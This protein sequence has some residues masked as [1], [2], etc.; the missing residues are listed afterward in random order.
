MI[1]VTDPDPEFRSWAVEVLDRPQ[2]TILTEDLADA[3]A[4]VTEPVNDVSVVLVGPNFDPDEGLRALERMH[5][6]V[7]DL[8]SILVSH[9]GESR[10]MQAAMR[11]GVRDVL[12]VPVSN[13]D[14]LEAVKRAQDLVTTLRRRS[15]ERDVPERHQGKVIT[16]FSSKGGCGKSLVSSNLAILLAQET[17]K[18]VALVDLD[19]QSGDQ[20][21]ML[22]LLPAL[23]I[24]DVSM[25]VDRID[26]EALQGYM[27]PH[28]AGIHVLAAPLEPSVAEAVTP[29]AV[30]RVLELLKETY[31]YIVVDGPAHFTD[32]ILAAFDLTD[33]LLMVTSMDV[34]SIKNLK[35]ALNTVQ[36]LGLSRDR[37]KVVLNR[38]DSKVGL[39]VS[40]V[41][42]TLGTEIDAAL[43]SSR[44]VPL[45][46]NQGVP[47]ALQRRKSP[48]V[49]AIAGLLDELAPARANDS[50]DES[51]VLGLFRRDKG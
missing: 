16:V 34:P 24:Y 28:R 48:V 23:S 12:T 39:R 4:A 1:V 3:E 27:T 41:E 36:Q 11:A 50:D 20:A 45:S 33:Q 25:N 19:L 29:E 9:T 37:I 22:Q 10:I 51:G 18:K 30:T 31:S 32:Q 21:I 38:A 26:A 15:G 13:E 8:G 6:R 2:Q 7:P 43:P 49:S 17:S 35:L 5:D 42:K 44:E 14:L 47:L 46:V 40:E